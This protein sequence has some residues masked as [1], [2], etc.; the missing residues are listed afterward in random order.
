MSGEYEK[1]GNSSHR[2]ANVM[3]KPIVLYRYFKSLFLKSVY[4]LSLL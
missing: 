1:N 4:I 3:M 2:Y